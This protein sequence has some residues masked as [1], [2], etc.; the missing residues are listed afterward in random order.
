LANRVRT[1]RGSRKS[2]GKSSLARG[3]GSLRV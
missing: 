1:N 3:V 2:A